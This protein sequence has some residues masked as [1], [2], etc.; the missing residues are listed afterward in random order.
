MLTKLGVVGG[1]AAVALLTTVSVRAHHASAAEFDG[2]KPVSLTGTV[3]KV[4]WL[5]P[6]IW[7]YID[8]KQADGTIEN[9]GVQVGA[10]NAL[11][12]KGLRKDSVDVGTEI[13]V[14]GFRAKDG[15]N[16]TSGRHVTFHDGRT[17]F[18]ESSETG[19][20]GDKNAPGDKKQ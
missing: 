12:R 7:I 14:L 16:A 4:E 10:P 19:A 3:T 1:V 8:V 15:R 2:D 5:N 20:P 18:L 9:W 6:H 11:M 17:L 13:K